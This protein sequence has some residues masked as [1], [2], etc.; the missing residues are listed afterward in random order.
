M[1]PG[2]LHILVSNG[3]ADGGF[4]DPHRLG[5]LLQG[6]GLEGAGAFK[7]GLLKGEQKLSQLQNGLSPLF[8][9]V[10]QKDRLPFLFAEI[11]SNGRVGLQGCRCCRSPGSA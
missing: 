3:T 2:G 8:H 7:K 1:S 9:T 10:A 5:C 6:Q 11:I 4:M